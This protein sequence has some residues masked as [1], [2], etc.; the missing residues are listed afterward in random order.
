[1]I[2]PCIPSDVKE[3]RVSRRYRGARYD[4]TVKNPDCLQHG[5]KTIVVNGTEQAGHTL[6]VFP[7]GT[8]VQ[9]EVIMG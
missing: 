3:Y 8:A 4:I 2:D 7:E 5:V 1:M 9:V 6:P